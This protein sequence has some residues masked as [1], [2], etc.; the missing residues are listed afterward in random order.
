[1]LKRC[2]QLC[3]YAWFIVGCGSEEVAPIDNQTFAQRCETPALPGPSPLRRLSRAE[4][5][6]TVYQ[7][8]AD[9]DPIADH[10]VPDG[11]ALGFTNQAS[12]VST[13]PLHV[14]QWLEASV[15]LAE[16]HVGQE[17]AALSSCA[18]SASQTCET[19]LS[20]WI[21]DFGLRVYR[22]PLEPVEVEEYADL[23]A[24]AAELDGDYQAK[25]GALAVIE[26]MLQSPQFLYRVEFGD[27]DVD[28]DGITTPTDWEMASRLS[29]LL[30]NTMPDVGLFE[31]AAQGELSTS[32]QI[33]S[34]AQ[35]MINTSRA[36]A[37][38]ANFHR[39]WLDLDK[40][41]HIATTG[42]D[43]EIY[44]DYDESIL[45]LLQRETESFLDYAIYEQNMSIDEFFTAPFTMMNKPLADWYGVQGPSGSEFKR[46]ELDPTRYAGILTQAGLLALHAKTNRSSPIHRGIFVREALLCQSPPAPP[47]NVPEPPEVDRTKTTREQFAE[48][49]QNDTC[50]GCHQL[51]DPI[52]LGFEHFDGLGRYRENEWGLAI[53]ARGEIVNG[54][55]ASGKFDGVVELGERLAG[56]EIVRDCMATQ[57]FRFSY[58]RGETSDDACS[59]QVVRADFAESGFDIKELI[60]A[61]TRTPAFRTMQ[62]VAPGAER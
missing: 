1:M 2:W 6:N 49:S 19:D 4:Y 34:H 61:L 62:V 13:S 5:N 17:L 56:S 21:G 57:W 12:A 22:R 8:F 38:I 31:A 7:L 35:R 29:Y 51:F 27:E 37:A 20:L 18:S 48:H 55:D 44:P 30:W 32:A 15:T 54:H 10:F 14:E 33:E 41:A 58:G 50:A 3:V 25:E 42:K 52:G 60:V 26:A 24:Q 47:D 45:P 40:V 43:S 36:R 53:D 23:F 16:K 11:E 9:L 39:Q 28:G 59:Q 46:V